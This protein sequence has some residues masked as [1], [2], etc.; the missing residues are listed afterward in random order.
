MRNDYFFVVIFCQILNI[1]YL[2]NVFS[3][4]GTDYAVNEQNNVIVSTLS[5]ANSAHNL[6]LGVGI[7]AS[8]ISLK[9]C[10]DHLS[11]F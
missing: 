6:P 4:N 11:I 10:L 1:D 2:F 9:S 8:Y 5:L 3:V 7:K